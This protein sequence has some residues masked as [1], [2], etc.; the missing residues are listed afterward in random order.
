MLSRLSLRWQLTLPYVLLVLA[1]A[2]VLALLSYRAGQNAV[3]NLSG[4]LLIETVNRIAQAVDRHVSG[5]AAVLESAFPK[6]VAAT[7]LGNRIQPAIDTTPP[8]FPPSLFEESR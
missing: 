5:S 2:G 1:L 6:G 8:S 3:D 7:V 4:Q